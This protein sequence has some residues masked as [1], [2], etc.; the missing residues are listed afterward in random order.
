MSLSSLALEDAV[1]GVLLDRLDLA[2]AARVPLRAR[3]ARREK[4]ARD[5]LRERGPDDPGAE[6]EH[7]H[8]VVLDALP[9]GKRVVAE[10][11]TDPRDLVR[12]HRRAHPAPADEN[13]PLASARHDGP[14]DLPREV[15]VVRGR[16]V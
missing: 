6:A 15:G 9:R 7:V 3:K 2:D 5:L 10:P 4:G 8:R 14:G 13:A 1:E 12:R 11:G 16:I